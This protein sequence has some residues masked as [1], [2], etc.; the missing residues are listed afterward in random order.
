M[1]RRGASR[2]S[3]DA[4][5]LL[6]YIIALA[7]EQNV[8][9]VLFNLFKIDGIPNIDISI[10]KLLMELEK[11]ELISGY[12]ITLDGGVTV[13]LTTDGIEY[14]EEKNRQYQEGFMSRNTNNFFGAVSNIQIQQGTV[15]SNQ[16]QTVFSNATIDFDKV[17]A[18]VLKIKKYDA[19]FDEEYGQQA[20]TLR[21]KL[22]EISVLAQKK[23]KPN[24][25]K[26]LLLE[27]KNL[28]VGVTGSLIA[29]GIVEGIK[30]LL[31]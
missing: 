27:L 26:S 3:K 20:A 7:Q 12:D 30:S 23:E 15:N 9:N 6:K 8:E 18:F 16:T 31:V 1:D 29:T 10:K 11:N 25:I 21:E 14:F 2:M 28:S 24:K 19:L 13:Y 5:R 17:E 22:E 4:E